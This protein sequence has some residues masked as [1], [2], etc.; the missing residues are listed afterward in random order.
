MDAQEPA[1]AATLRAAAAVAYQRLETH[2]LNPHARYHLAHLLMIDGAAATAR[3]YADEALVRDPDNLL[4]LGLAASAAEGMGDSAAVAG[5]HGRFRAHYE[6]RRD[7][8]AYAA[9]A[10]ELE[11]FRIAAEERPEQY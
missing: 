10:D 2:A 8:P 9:H 7:D 6:V 1:R 3:L 11:E 4:N 5:Y